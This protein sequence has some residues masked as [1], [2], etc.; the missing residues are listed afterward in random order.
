M[1]TEV[2]EPPRDAN[3]IPI[4]PGYREPFNSETG[5]LNG[6]K[7]NAIRWKEPRQPTP[8][9]TPQQLLESFQHSRPSKGFFALMRRTQRRMLNQAI[10]ETDVTRMAVAVQSAVDVFN[11]EQRLLGRDA[12]PSKSKK[13]SRSKLSPH[14]LPMPDPVSQESGNQG[15]NPDTAKP[16]SGQATSA[17]PPDS[18]SDCPF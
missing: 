8:P 16:A 9:K 1:S 15:V 6:A 17:S 10:A 4:L 18:A 7:G 3:G 12:L 5:R 13:P 14:D 2:L 11:M